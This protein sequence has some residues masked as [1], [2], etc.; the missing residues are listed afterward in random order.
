MYPIKAEVRIDYETIVM[1]SKLVKDQVAVRL[2]F[3]NVTLPDAFRNEGLPMSPIQN[4]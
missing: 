2:C 3:N 1:S 4:L